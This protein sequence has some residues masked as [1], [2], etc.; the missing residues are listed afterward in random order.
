MRARVVRQAQRGPRKMTG[1]ILIIVAQVI[2]AVQ[3]VVEEKL[4]GGYD[5]LALQA[6]GWEGLWGTS[7]P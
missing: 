4:I 7:P 1:N 3:M 6:G 2:V 5:I